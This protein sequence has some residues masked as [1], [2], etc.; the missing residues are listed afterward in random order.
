MG[1]VYEAE[2]ERPVRRRVALKL[3]KLGMDTREVVARFESE[4]QALA[5]LNHPY[6]A[7]VYDAGSTPEG[8][9]YFVMEYVP[10]IS[11]CEYC[12][13]NQLSIERRLGL[14]QQICEAVQHAHQKGIIHRDLKNSNILV[15]TRQEGPVPKIIDFGLAKAIGMRLSDVTLHTQMGQVVGTLE[16]ISP[17]QA[18]VTPFDVDTR[19]DVYSLGV[20]LYELLVGVRPIERSS[21]GD[22]GILHLIE[23]IREEEPLWPSMK[24]ASIGDR[25]SEIAS[26]RG[27]DPGSLQR[28]LHGDLDW[29]ALKALEKDRA[30]R[31]GSASEFSADLRRHMDHEPVVAS[32]PS[33]VYRVWKFVRRHRVGVVGG[34]AV[35]LALLVGIVGTTL[36]L[37]RATRAERSARREA[38]TAKRTTDVLVELF[39][40]AD[41]EHARG[42]TITSREILDNGAQRVRRELKGEPLVQARLMSA[43]GNVYHGLGLYPSSRDL[44]KEALEVRTRVL[45]SDDPEIAAN[46]NDLAR[47]LHWLGEFDEGA[48]DAQRALEINEKTLG[49]R[50]VPTAWSMYY[51][52]INLARG[53][54]VGRQDALLRG[55]LPIFQETLGQNSLA[56]AWCLNDIGISLVTRERYREALSPFREALRIKERILGRDAPDV[57]LAHNNVAY[58][59]SLLGDY[60]D[61]EQEADRA[62]SIAR[63]VLG[64]QHPWT[65]MWLHTKGDILRREGRLREA[66]PTLVEAIAIQ[67]ASRNQNEELPLSLCTL[68]SL[69]ASL[70]RYSEAEAG[71]KRSIALYEAIDPNHPALVPCLEEFARLCEHVGK[72][73]EALKLRSRAEKIR[74]LVAGSKTASSLAK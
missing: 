73:A 60:A 69:R 38:E 62:V 55:A 63:R 53:R 21:S 16:Y 10:G 3:I 50:S 72:S 65:A 12:D 7:Q 58:V 41:P 64:S 17:E 34:V 32:P 35:A 28:A 47:T 70:G 57:G 37:I 43:I 22:T 31:Y 52:A 42:D 59:E 26:S 29:I 54:D 67:E 44:L 27:T 40:V 39:Q 66:E 6:I 56:V 13:R 14:F 30:R 4:R 11:I 23:R 71:F 18:W 20:L 68:A 5:V 2:Q 33:T 51:L 25:S 1:E 46:L 48:M 9:P 19:S 61:A 15:E 45:G 8:R 24:L 74:T 49:P 36:M